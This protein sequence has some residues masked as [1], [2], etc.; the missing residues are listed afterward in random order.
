MIT[1]KSD[2]EI[3]TILRTNSAALDMSATVTVQKC[4][5][6]FATNR[7]NIE[8][9]LVQVWWQPNRLYTSEWNFS[10][11]RASLVTIKCHFCTLPRQERASQSPH[12]V[13]KRFNPFISWTNWDRQASCE[14]KLVVFFSYYY[15]ANCTNLLQFQGLP[16]VL[17]EYIVYVGIC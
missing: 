16:L 3:S 12:K 15:F 2:F 9:V 17:W 13:C 5:R 8:M 4:K 6:Q 14:G 10:P 7:W 1:W 11:K